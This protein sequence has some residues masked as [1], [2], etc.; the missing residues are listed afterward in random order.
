VAGTESCLEERIK[1]LPDEE[2]AILPP[3]QRFVEWYVR[4]DPQAWYDFSFNSSSLW[5][6]V[7]PNMPMF[8]YLYGVV[9]RDLDITRGLETFDTPVLLA[10]G[11][12]DFIV[13]PPRSWDSVRPKFQNLTVRVFE[14]SGHSPQYEEPANFN[15]ELV[16]WLKANQ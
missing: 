7:L 6:G 9:L 8:D 12:F 13:A 3:A 10:L 5:K 4:R 15:E 1:R 16:R 14:H 2:L 11:R